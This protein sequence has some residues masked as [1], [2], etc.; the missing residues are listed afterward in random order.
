LKYG[1]RAVENDGCVV[2][3]G[4]RFGRKVAAP[5]QHEI[6]RAQFDHFLVAYRPRRRGDRKQC[7]QGDQECTDGRLRGMRFEIKKEDGLSTAKYGVSRPPGGCGPLPGEHLDYARA[8]AA[9]GD[10]KLA[11]I[12]RRADRQLQRHLRAERQR[13]A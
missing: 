10:V 6:P 9:R 4:Q 1:R 2:V 11:A 5:D 3:F 8:D 12:G 13:P 7:K